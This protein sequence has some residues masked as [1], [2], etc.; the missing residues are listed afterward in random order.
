MRSAA[1]CSSPVV[2]RSRGGD[3]PGA[4]ADKTI[5]PGGPPLPCNGGYIPPQAELSLVITV[6]GVRLDVPPNRGTGG[7]RGGS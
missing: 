1:E 3:L 4:V 7:G 2:L 5:L 6:A